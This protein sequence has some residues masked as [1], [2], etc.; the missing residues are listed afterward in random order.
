MPPGQRRIGIE[1]PDLLVV[2]LCR[3]RGEVNKHIIAEQGRCTPTVGERTI[4]V[5]VRMLA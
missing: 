4:L 2:E 1:G 3:D 5:A